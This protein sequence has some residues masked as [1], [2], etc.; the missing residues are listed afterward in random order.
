MDQNDAEDSRDRKGEFLGS[1]FGPK[2][3]VDIGVAPFEKFTK[4]D[5]SKYLQN[6]ES[7]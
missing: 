7:G 2:A 5:G 3:R 4:T 6:W 1:C